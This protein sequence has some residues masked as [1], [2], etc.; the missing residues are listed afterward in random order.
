MAFV[1]IPPN[2]QD[3]FNGIY[4]RLSKLETGPN[5]P[6]YVAESA[7]G[8]AASAAAQAANAETQAVQA[9]ALAS[10][11]SLQ[12]TQA[13]TS[14]DGKNSIYYSTSTPGSTPNKAGDIWY[15]YGTVA[16]YVNKVI[17]QWSG[18]GGTSWTSTGLSGLVLST[19]DAGSITTGTLNAIEITAGDSSQSTNFH[20]SPTGYMAA[21]GAYIQ[22]T[23]T[24]DQGIFR[25]SLYSTQGTIAQ[26]NI[27]QY[28]MYAT[29]QG[30]LSLDTASGSVVAGGTSY[31]TK[32]SVNGATIG[33]GYE[34]AVE[35]DVYISNSLEVINSF[36]ANSAYTY[37]S[38]RFNGS[39][40]AAGRFDI[41]TSGSVRS[42]YTYNI[43]RSS[44]TRAVIIDDVGNIGTSASTRRK[45]HEIENYAI[46]SNA[47]LQ[48]PVRTFKYKP[49]IDE[50]QSVQY[51]FIAE[52][53]Q[54]LGL[55][56]LIQY[57]ADGIP[58]YF[59]YEK[60][61]IFLLQLIQEQDK[62]IKDLEAKL[63]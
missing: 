47:L 38:V 49:E 17:A 56:E 53:A 59:A 23:I 60:L 30:V 52:E 33:T 8:S 48:L 12:A 63:Q 11:A 13:Q 14:A 31:L 57:D 58:D 42:L 51:G 7:Q 35:G 9:Q 43:A 5:Q 18:A 37:G 27:D 16:P 41:F 2:L 46:N 55:D 50:T 20:V 25:G 36:T 39:A 6:L 24:A 4:D 34:M 62:R 29:A 32:L 26:F 19:L 3:M 28:G 22:G 10:I 21:Q 54:D 40:G 61:P 15:Q 45:K 1:N 44:N